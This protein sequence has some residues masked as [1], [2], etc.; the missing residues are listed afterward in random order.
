MAAGQREADGGVMTCQGRDLCEG[1]LCIQ[2]RM[3]GRVYALWLLVLEKLSERR[4][5][6]G[7]GLGGEALTGDRGSR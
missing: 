4:E 3:A 2:H 6:K 1:A 7:E 5:E